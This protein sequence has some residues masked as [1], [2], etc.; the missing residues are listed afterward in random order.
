M[1]PWAAFMRKL[2][3]D[4]DRLELPVDFDMLPVLPGEFV[5]AALGAFEPVG[6]AGVAGPAVVEGVPEGL[7]GDVDC[8]PVCMATASAIDPA[9]HDS[10]CRVFIMSYSVILSRRD[11]AM[12]ASHRAGSIP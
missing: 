5:P 12:P 2:R 10:E 9:S 4:D 11:A 3:S 8:A 7:A 1:P 6:G